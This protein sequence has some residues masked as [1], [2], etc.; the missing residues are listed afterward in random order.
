MNGYARI[1]YPG[2][3]LKIDF[4]FEG[5]EIVTLIIMSDEVKVPDLLQILPRD[6][7]Y[8]LRFQAITEAN[9]YLHRKDHAEET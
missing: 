8:Q 3:N 2:T 5:H 9:K 4:Y 7:A 1:P 6:I